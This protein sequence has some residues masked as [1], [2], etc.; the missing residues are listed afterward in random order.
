[1]PRIT[2]N[3]AQHIAE[4]RMST[5]LWKRLRHTA[6]EHDTNASEL[7]RRGARW[8]VAY[9]QEHGEMP[10]ERATVRPVETGSDGER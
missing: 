1:M 8:A 6:I 5:A 2:A 7:M 10:P 9:L 4:V 3:G